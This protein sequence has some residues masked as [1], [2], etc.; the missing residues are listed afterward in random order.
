MDTV[1]RVNITVRPKGKRIV[2]LSTLANIYRGVGL[3]LQHLERTGHLPRW[4]IPANPFHLAFGIQKVHI[5]LG[6]YIVKN[7]TVKEI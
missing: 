6:H 2:Q 7:F 4:T 3:K 1:F 5:R